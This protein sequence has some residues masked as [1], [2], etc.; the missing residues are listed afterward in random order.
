MKKYII[1]ICSALLLSG[2]FIGSSA[3]AGQVTEVVTAKS[4][5]QNTGNIVKDSKGSVCY[6]KNYNYGNL[7]K[8]KIRVRA[9]IGGDY[10]NVLA[11]RNLPKDNIT[12]RYILDNEINAGK[13]MRFCYKLP[14][15]ATVSSDSCKITYNLY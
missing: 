1:G 3:S 9:K 12:Y 10:V 13:L 6:A 7:N 2:M 15:N 11:S 5:W 8:T 4:S 14:D